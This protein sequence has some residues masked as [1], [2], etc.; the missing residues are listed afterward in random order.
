MINLK[1]ANRSELI[2]Y[3]ESWGFACYDNEPT[4]KLREAALL[5]QETE[6]SEDEVT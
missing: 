2:T 4:E 5:N 6:E 1:Q 3:L